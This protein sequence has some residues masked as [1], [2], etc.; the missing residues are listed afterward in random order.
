M[1]TAPDVCKTP[2]PTG[3]VPVPYVNI[4]QCNMI[5][6]NTASSKVFFDGAPALTVKSKTAVSNGDEAG[7]AGGGVVSGK[8]VGK[9]EF[10]SNV[11]KVKIENSPGVALGA[12]TKHNDGNCVGLNSSPSQTKV[13]TR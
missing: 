4:F 6:P 2:S 11:Q 5:T 12:Q 7:N 10:I 9:G 1:S 13:Q 8:F 3:T